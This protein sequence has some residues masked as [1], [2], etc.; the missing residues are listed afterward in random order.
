MLVSVLGA[1][2]GCG[3][4][5][6]TCGPGTAD[7]DEDN[8]C[9]PE[10]EGPACGPGTIVDE[11]TGSCLPNPGL[12]GPGQV[13]ANGVCVTLPVAVD[14]EEGA[15]P[16]GLGPLD[17]PAGVLTFSLESRSLSLHGC[18]VPSGEA[19]D[20]DA[21]LVTIDAP[22]YLG[23][24]VTGTGGLIAGFLVRP[25]GASPPVAGYERFGLAIASS[26]AERA[27]YLPAAGT[28]AI[29]IADTRSLLSI[30][31][32]DPVVA[33]GAVDGTSCYL[34]AVEQLERPPDLT[35]TPGTPATGTLTT[36]A[37]VYRAT[38]VTGGLAV[39]LTLASSFAKA[40]LTVFVGDALVAIGDPTAAV[41]GLAETDEVR[42]IV[43]TIYDLGLAPTSYSLDLR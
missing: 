6:K 35:I 9:E 12:C 38:G 7:L 19:A 5:A 13:L 22:T 2:L 11:G 28:Y 17:P 18:I 14:L 16:N 27:V 30:V 26:T 21:Y 31:R 24:S 32:G 40:G 42:V 41:T 10:R 29:A 25:L 4:N 36:D 8:R 3:D 15:E 37:D 23:I 39:E 20:F 1:G 33:A 34:A 43:D